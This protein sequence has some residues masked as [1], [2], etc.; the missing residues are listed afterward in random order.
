MPDN[1]IAK[2]VPADLREHNLEELH[3]GAKSQPSGFPMGNGIH[4]AMG[5][6]HFPPHEAAWHVIQYGPGRP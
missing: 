3:I 6:G 2:A 4:I 1:N 5:Q